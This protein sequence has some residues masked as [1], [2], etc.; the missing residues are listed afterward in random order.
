MRLVHI[1]PSPIKGKK[2]EARFETDQGRS[3]TTHFGATGYSD[4]TQHKDEDRKERYLKRHQATEDWNDPTSA[5]ALSRWI[6]WNKPTL[7]G[8]VRDFKQRFHLT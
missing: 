1:I 4:F 7:L 8:S 6:L 3:I 5:G 2:Y